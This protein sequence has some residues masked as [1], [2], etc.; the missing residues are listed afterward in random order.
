MKNII[1]ILVPLLTLLFAG[2]G[3][4]G[5][6]FLKIPVDARVVGMG[7]AAVAYID[8]ASALY[9]NPAG[10]GSI[11]TFDFLVMHNM[12]L[13]GMGHEYAALAFPAGTI[14]SFGLSFNYWGSGSIQGYN[15][16]GDSIPSFSASDWVVALGY[17]KGLGSFGFG[18]GIMYLRETNED[19]NA[20]TISFNLGSTYALPVKGLHLGLSVSNLS[21]SLELDQES[22]SLPMQIRMGWRYAFGKV[23]FANDYLVGDKFMFMVGTEYWMADVMALRLGYKNDSGLDGIS[24][25]R[26]G[27]GFK[28]K[29]FGIDYGF[30][31]YG[32]LGFSH[33]FTLSFGSE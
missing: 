12:W 30:A 7:E 20:S 18:F 33:R 13:L 32:K 31:P 16:R 8:N 19:Y 22:F 5:A 4:N 29:K 6:A 3:D 2:P 11:K 1:I 9:Y 17:G 15:I 21:G 27:V 23:V 14:G 28:I 24:G 10:L 26:A 25:L